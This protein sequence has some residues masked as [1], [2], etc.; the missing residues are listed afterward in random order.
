MRTGFGGRPV[1]IGVAAVVLLAGL[2]LAWFGLAAPAA[3]VQGQSQVQ[4]KGQDQSFTLS[5]EEEKVADLTNSARSDA[6]LPPL[7]FS[8]E[9]TRSAEA[10]AT[11]MQQR[12]YFSHNSPEGESPFALMSRYGVDYTSAGENLAQGPSIDRMFAS[13]MNSPEHKKNILSPD[14]THLGVGVV[15]QG[16]RFTAVQHFARLRNA[17]K[18]YTPAPAAP[19]PAPSGSALPAPSTPAPAAPTP[20]APTPTAPTPAAPAQP[21]KGTYVVQPGDSLYLI[22]Q[23]LGIPVWRLIVANGWEVLGELRPGQVIRL[24]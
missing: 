13:W 6:G 10:K 9:L 24:P 5:P 20:A 18:D 2:S 21:A 15:S 7:R 11:D 16:G 17:G 14:Y 23:K 4:T 12:G 22:G 3:P 1:R 8:A 19:S